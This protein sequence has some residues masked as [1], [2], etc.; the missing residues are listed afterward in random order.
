MSQMNQLNAIT[1]D[2][3]DATGDDI[4]DTHSKNTPTKYVK[5]V[6]KVD[7]IVFKYLNLHLDDLPD[8]NYRINFDEGMEPECMAK[9]IIEPNIGPVDDL[10]VDVDEDSL[11]RKWMEKVEHIVYAYLQMSTDDLPDENYRMNFDDGMTPEEM[12]KII[13][14][15]MD[16]LIHDTVSRF[17]N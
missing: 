10:D 13:V 3:C 1:D 16:D 6:N 2:T 11:Y 14:G 8:E 15:P 7:K 5:W 12:A 17:F 9:I 4:Y